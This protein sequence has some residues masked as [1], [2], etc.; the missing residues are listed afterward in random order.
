MD[1]IVAAFWAVL[2]ATA[3]V[4]IPTIWRLTA[5]DVPALR[6]PLPI[7]GWPRDFFGVYRAI[8]PAVIGGWL[9]LVGFAAASNW[10]PPSRP[11]VG[12]VAIGAFF[13]L[14][15]GVWAARYGTPRFLVAP[16]L[17]A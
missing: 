5:A 9:L 12:A 4:R 16:A 14:G 1:V 10:I 13:A 17:R 6:R 3:T 8:I 15:V 2:V 7:A 11:L